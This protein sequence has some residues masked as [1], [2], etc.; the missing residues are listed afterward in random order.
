MPPGI[1]GVLE[2]L[3]DNLPEAHSAGEPGMSKE[4]AAAAAA[5]GVQKFSNEVKR[6]E[7][8][9]C[10]VCL[11]VSVQLGKKGVLR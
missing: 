2:D 6:S 11:E 8:E 3:P 1:G 4:E 9:P 10:C 7:A 5:E